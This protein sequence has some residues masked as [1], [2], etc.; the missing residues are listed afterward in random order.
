MDFIAPL[1]LAAFGVAALLLGRFTLRNAASLV[2][3][4]TD[5]V[6][7]MFGDAK[8]F[9][10]LFA[11]KPTSNSARIAGIGFLLVGAALLVIGVIVLIV[12]VAT[13]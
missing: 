13:P 3:N 10:A 2:S 1:V 8:Q 5:E 7:Q 9:E 12:G 4:S 6:A 11:Q